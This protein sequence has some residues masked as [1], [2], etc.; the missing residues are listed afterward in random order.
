MAQYHDIIISG[1]T[2]VNLQRKTELIISYAFKVYIRGDA[3]CVCREDIIVPSEKTPNNNIFTNQQH[4][5]EL[6]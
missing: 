1:A 5:I 2:L 4:G 6:M 3:I